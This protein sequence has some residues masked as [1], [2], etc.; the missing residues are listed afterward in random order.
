QANKLFLFRDRFGIKPLYYYHD[1]SGNFCFAS[2]LKAI[3][4]IDSIERKVNSQ[5][6]AYFLH[7]GFV[8]AP[9]TMYEKV[10]KLESGNFL[11]IDRNGF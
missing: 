1:S 3:L 8:P 7:T 9:L 6:V 5:A 4:A 10:F 11:T 2:E